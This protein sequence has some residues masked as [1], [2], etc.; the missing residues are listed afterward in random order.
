MPLRRLRLNRLAGVL[1]LGVLAWLPAAAQNPT[2][3]DLKA[4]VVL[5]AL[6]FV[7]WPQAASAGGQPLVM[8]VLAAGPLAAALDKLRGERINGRRLDVRRP[9]TAEAATGCHASYVGAAEAAALAP[10]PGANL[11]FGDAPGLLERGVMLNLQI[12]QNRVVFDI[13]LAA[14]RRA[15]ID[16]N[17]RLL[18]LARFVRQEL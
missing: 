14:A 13:N 17:T 10:R 1:A 15:G 7:E 16:I 9:A 6:L 18:R 5:G 12:D 11:L 2:E 8:C 4:R 3:Q